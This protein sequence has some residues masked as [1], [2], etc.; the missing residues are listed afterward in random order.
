MRKTFRLP[1]SWFREHL[2]ILRELW[3]I[4][5]SRKKVTKLTTE[6]WLCGEDKEA[7]RGKDQA[8]QA[9]KCIR[10]PSRAC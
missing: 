2:K 3:A 4:H 10:M 9:F 8:Y 7:W 6:S 1:I 5:R